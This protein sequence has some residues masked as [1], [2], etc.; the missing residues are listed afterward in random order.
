MDQTLDKEKT[1]DIK[2]RQRS[3]PKHK[4]KEM[5]KFQVKRHRS[6]GT[7]KMSTWSYKRQSQKEHIEGNLI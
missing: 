5:E 7:L 2:D 6:K 3:D 4:F 1:E